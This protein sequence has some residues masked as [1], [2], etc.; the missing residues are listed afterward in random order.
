MHNDLTTASSAL[1]LPKA[2][3]KMWLW[4]WRTQ[5]I[6][7]A[8]LLLPA[9][10]FLR[11]A[12][13]RGVFY[14]HDIQYYFY[15]YHALTAALVANGELP[16]WNAYAFSGIPLL[17]DGQTAMFYPPNWLFFL[18]PGNAAL[19]YD[20]L[21]QFSIAGAGLFWF[22]RSLGLWRLPAFLGALAYMF[23]GFLTARVVH[24]SILSGAALIPLLF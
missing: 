24:L 1:P 11:P 19:N 7:G 10:V 15:P 23:C 5:L 3:T 20:V 9:V 21:I 17:G 14:F 2:F 16:L 22:A 4:R 18:L 12:L 13:L 6:V 8:L